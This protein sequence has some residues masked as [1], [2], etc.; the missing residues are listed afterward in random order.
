MDGF[1]LLVAMHGTAEKKRLSKRSR[2]LIILGAMAAVILVLLVVLLLAAPSFLRSLAGEKGSDLLGRDVRIDGPVHIAWDW[3]KPKIELSKLR[4]GNVKESTSPDMVKLDRAEFRLHI[5]RL[6]LGEVRLD[7]VILEKP[8]IV[9]E[10]FAE[11]RKN[12]EFPAFSK[13]ATV[14][15]A[16]V[17]SDRHN[18]PVIGRMVLKDGTLVY[19]DVDK[20]LNLTLTLS[21]AE[22]SS[23]D[24][25][26]ARLA[27]K[28]EGMLQGKTFSISADGGSLAFLRGKSEPYPL[29]LEI[30]MGNT[31]AMIDGSFAD[32]VKLKGIDATLE[33]KGDNLAD[34]FHLTTIPLPPSPP[35]SLT[36]HLTEKDDVWNFQGFNGKVGDSDLAGD[37]SFDTSGERGFVKAMLTSNRLD[38]DDLA[39]FIG[40]PP[41]TKAG[42][43]ASPEQKQQAAARAASSRLLP[44]VPINLTRLRATDMDVTL[45]AKKV[46]APGWPMQDLLV[47]FDLREGL[48]KLDPLSFGMA[49]GRLEG[50]LVLDGRDDI[51]RVETNLTVKR[52]SLKQ[53]FQNTQ[54]AALSSGHFGGRIILKGEG[55]SLADVL[56]TSDGR[57]TLL[58]AGGSVSLLLVEAAGID[59]GEAS[60]LLLGKDKAT[61]IRCAVGDFG[62]Q[63]GVLASDL[64]VLDTDDT[65]LDGEA[66]INLKD[67]S[68]D[69]RM[70]A[71]P[72]DISIGATR[73]PVTISG[74][75]KNPSIGLDPAELG[76][77]AGTAAVLSAFLTPLAALI[78]FIEFG[79]G[80]DSDCRSLIAEARKRSGAANPPP[81]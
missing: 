22:G 9:L 19:R 63:D 67:E 14:S 4:L 41:S 58:M 15:T 5:W 70:E 18:F 43:T 77:R 79:L 11:D 24:D 12:W 64:F 52:M 3:T 49:D 32:P 48:L 33:L 17:P 76:A 55:R 6:L 75:L 34:L 40:A 30:I 29:K 37:L 8:E 66:R 61:H 53:Y 65:N 42:E 57:I 46:N 45:K 71:H 59:I 60:S 72:K 54:F 38:M 27:L 21:T 1:L 20:K 56:S 39:G 47:R 80:E 74:R 44:D 68:I 62:V 69:A 51:P 7:D 73:T 13:A 35:Y 36:G 10:K 2:F 23:G 25:A 31:R 78:P 28:G 50:A 81:P 16:V 26:G